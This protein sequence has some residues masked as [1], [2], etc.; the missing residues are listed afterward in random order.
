MTGGNGG[1]LDLLI[2]YA[3]ADEELHDQLAKHLKPLERE[4]VIRPWHDRRITPGREF[5]GAIDEK[6]DEAELILLLISPDFVNSEY[7]WEKEMLRAMERHEAGEAR[8]IPVILR[9]TDWHRTPFG[10]LLALPKDGKAITTW[11]NRDQA[12]LD[13]AQ[14]VRAAAGEWNFRHGHRGS[15]VSLAVTDVGFTNDYHGVFINADIANPAS[16]PA[17]ILSCTL[18]IPELSISLQHVPGPGNL[19]VGAPWFER[20][21]FL[22]NARMVSRGAF[23]FRAGMS[24]LKNGLPNEPLE[25]KLRV[26]FFLLPP[27]EQDVEIFTA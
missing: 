11:E 21:P 2:S 27:L 16:K 23:F 18:Q 24:A 3:H 9:P 26:E 15:S 8:V 6:L 22:I 7:C 5:E 13:V 1:A 17:Q 12:Y 10:K 14:G 19:M 25:A 4:G 20:T